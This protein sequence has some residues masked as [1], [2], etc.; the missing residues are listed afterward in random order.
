M[1]APIW[2]VTWAADEFSDCVSVFRA[3]NS[4]PL[5]SAS[6]MRLTALTPP[7]P[8]P[9]T[10]S[11][12][13]R[14]ASGSVELHSYSAAGRAGFGGDMMFSGRSLENAWRRRSWG[15]GVRGAAGSSGG[16]STGGSGGGCAAAVS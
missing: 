7:P 1:S 14:V 3:M 16:A 4:T 8:T 12:G 10:R 5:T 6:I 13:W 11:S 2:S 15:V 9:I